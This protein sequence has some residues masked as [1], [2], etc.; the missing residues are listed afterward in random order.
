MMIDNQTSDPEYR[1]GR[2]G[3]YGS[4]LLDL[5]QLLPPSDFRSV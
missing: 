3:V 5:P 2:G 4:H 1:C